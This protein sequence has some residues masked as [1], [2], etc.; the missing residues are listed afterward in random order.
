M[1]RSISALVELKKNWQK[2]Q[3]LNINQGEGEG[4]LQ[5]PRRAVLSLREITVVSVNIEWRNA[6]VI[7]FVA[8][9]N[10]LIP[11]FRQNKKKDKLNILT[12]KKQFYNLY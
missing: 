7:E 9:I 4:V 2:R 1:R 11:V 10:V 8:W 12:H 5:K 6:I 3:Q